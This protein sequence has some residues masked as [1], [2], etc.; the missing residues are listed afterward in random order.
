MA[1]FWA[2]IANYI[3]L[4]LYLKYL[5]ASWYGILS[6]GAIIQSVLLL[7]NGG[8]SATLS[9]EFAATLK[10]NVYRNELFYTIEK[11]LLAL[12]SAGG[13][14]LFF[15][16]PSIVNHWLNIEVQNIPTAI[17]ALRLLSFVIIGQIFFFF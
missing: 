9:R 6:F 1:T 3:F 11:L 15:L 10:D 2:I 7:F 5:G 13:M 4:P 16:I 14:V 12:F 8:F 17:L